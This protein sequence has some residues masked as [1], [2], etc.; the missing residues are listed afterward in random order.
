MENPQR[1][2]KIVDYI[3]QRH[4]QKTHHKDYSAMFAVSSIDTLIKYYD[5]FKQKK[6]AG[7]HDLRIA[8]IFTYGANEEDKGATGAL[9]AQEDD[10]FGIAAEPMTVYTASHTRDKLEEYIGDYNAMYGTSFSTKDSQSFQNYYKDLSKRLKEREKDNFDDEKHRLD[11]VLVVSMM[12]TGFDAKKVN[13]LY[14]D[15]NLRYHGLIQ[16]FS[17][18]NRILGEVKSQGNI[19]CF[20]NLKDRTDEAITLFSNKDANEVIFTPPFEDVAHEFNEV[21][22]QLTQLTP[23]V[24]SVDELMHEDEQLEFVKTFEHSCVCLTP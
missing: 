22:E 15:K 8:T 13:T 23:T 1:L 20:R 11:I 2:D 10:E 12:L 4:D 16:A 24:E 19:L 7:E 6:D 14:V 9:P 18:T 21:Y 17:R 3:I 5:L